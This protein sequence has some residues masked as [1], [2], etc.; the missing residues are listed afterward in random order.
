[1]IPRPFAHPLPRVQP[2]AGLIFGRR[3]G[4]KEEKPKLPYTF[5]PTQEDY[6]WYATTR[7]GSKKRARAA[8]RALDLGL[9]VPLTALSAPLQY[10]IA[11]AIYLSD[12]FSPFYTQERIGKDGKPFTIVK[13][14]TMDPRK[15]GAHFT[16]TDDPRI[17]RIGRALRASR[18]DELPQ[19]LNVLKGEMSLVGPRAQVPEDYRQLDEFR[20]RIVVRPGLTGPSQL[21]EHS[22][23]SSDPDF[24]EKRLAA[25]VDL[26][27]GMSIR[28]QMRWIALTGLEP[29]NAA[30]EIVEKRRNRPNSET[31]HRFPRRS[32]RRNAPTTELVG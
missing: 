13:F 7:H 32:Q 1:M 2:D 23:D 18:L 16:T 17:T 19:F 31:R 20:R 3:F 24:Y 12:G 9:G 10:A 28:E 4:R 14:R 29:A 8:Q 6:D 22:R 15:Q 30:R 27:N 25:D 11:S 21:Q 5:S 26:I